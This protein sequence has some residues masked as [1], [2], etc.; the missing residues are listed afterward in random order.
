MARGIALRK[1]GQ[2]LEALAVFQTEW[3]ATGALQALV[4]VA[5]AEQALGRWVDAHRHLS[6]ALAQQG[7][8]WLMRHAEPLRAALAEIASK[9]GTLDVVCNVS[10]AELRF[11]GRL[12]GHAPL[13]APVLVPAGRG[14]LEVRSPAHFEVLRQVEIDAGALSRVEVNLVSNLPSALP[15]VEPAPAA[16]GPGGR[17]LL[18]YS[19]LGLTG[20]GVAAGVTGLIVRAVNLKTWNDDSRCD[21]EIGP[22]RADECPAEDRAWRTGQAVAIAGFATAAVF[23]GV[24]LYLWLD[25][26]EDRPAAALACSAIFAGLSCEA[27][28]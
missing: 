7:D 18:F 26:E 1:A 4:Q 12:L 23:G 3:Q 24:S 19:S 9:L 27:H 5:L 16:T 20:L 13:A 2:D 14:A 25:R 10:G 22:S 11:D 28:F 17:E 8:A 6:E 15:A 21:T